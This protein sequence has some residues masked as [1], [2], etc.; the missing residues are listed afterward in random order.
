MKKKLSL[1]ICALS[2]G[3]FAFAQA[4]YKG[5]ILNGNQV[6]G[7]KV[8]CATDEHETWLQQND[9]SRAQARQDYEANIQSYIA[10]HPN[11]QNRS[12]ITI[13]VVVHIVYYTGAPAQNISDNQ[14]FSQIQV[15][16]ED[17]GRTNSDVNTH[18]SQASGT[19]IQ[20]CLAQRDPNGNATNGIE[21]RGL[22]SNVSFSTNDGVKHYSSNGLDAWD[23]TRYMNIWVCNLGQSL[24]GYGEF[25]TT[26]VSQ[27]FGVV[28]L[29]SAF[30]SN[31]TSYG[32]FSD[33]QSPYDRG[34]TTTH[35]FSHCFNLYHIWGDDNG[36]CSGS[37]NCSDTPNQG[38]ATTTCYSFPHTDNCSTSSPG[39]MF[40]NYMD[41]SY[42]N[43]LNLFTAGQSAR[44][45]AVLSSAPY[46]A[47][48]TSNGCQPLTTTPL[49]AGISSITTPANNATYCSGTFT[50]VVVLKNFG[51]STLTSCVINYKIDNNT[52]QTYNWSGSLATNA[53]AN[54]TLSSQ[55]ATNGTHT[56]TCYTSSPNGGTDGQTSNDQS[57]NTFTVSGTGQ[58][59]PY[60]QGFESTTFVPTGWTLNNPDGSN[61]WARTTT[62]H[63]SGSAC[64]FMDNWSYQTGNGQIDEMTMPALNLSS[65][66]NPV[67]T[68]QVAY[69]Y[70]TVPYQYSDTLKIYISTDCGA[71]WTQIYNKYGSN[72]Q[73]APP[74][75][76]TTSP[77]T[78]SSTQW[79]L[80]TISLLPYQSAGSAMIKFR[81]ISD[82]EDDL[83]L[84]DINIT[85]TTDV[86]TFN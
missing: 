44:M 36:S 31:F 82:Y 60:T 14:V 75:S 63:T 35:E 22:S 37:D 79:R 41:Y 74:V 64:A 6:P 8:R 49:D 26:S 54:V 10:A 40:E 86:P 65:V 68:F 19:N 45:N 38:N 77:F 29:Y 58:S 43:C 33:I 7:N 30:G 76:S 20:F 72:L 66:S 57:Q 21:R 1:L 67:M 84:D 9:P 61:T 13:P 25:P 70:W 3:G 85:N 28:I 15:V 16:N 59:L 56:F 52:V 71:T 78:P 17:Y 81:N 27:T 24:L 62:A 47:L 2:L 5:K 50:P 46:N 4:P 42:D 32:T 12:T 55:T 48:A 51:S 39:I 23:P 18:W 69:T 11:E 73:T 34:R 53:T 80:E 83:Y